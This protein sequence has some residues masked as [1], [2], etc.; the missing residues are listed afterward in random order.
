MFYVHTVATET[1][2]HGGAAQD[3]FFVRQ[4]HPIFPESKPFSAKYD[5]RNS[6]KPPGIV[7]SAT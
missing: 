7:L 5:S 6:T 3:R 4:T 1:P 2:A